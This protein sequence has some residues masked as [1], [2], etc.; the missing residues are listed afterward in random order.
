MFEV[1]DFVVAYNEICGYITWI[2]HK[3]DS[4]DV[5]WED[6]DLPYA[7][8]AHIPFKYLKKVES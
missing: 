5:E 1:G 7:K 2:D 4:A 6:D 3:N 8:C